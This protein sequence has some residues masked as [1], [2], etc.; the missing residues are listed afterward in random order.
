MDLGYSG[1]LQAVKQADLWILKTQWIVDLVWILSRIPYCA[2]LDVQILGS[3]QKLDHSFFF[4]FGRYVNLMSSS[5]LLLFFEWSSFKL[6]CETVSGIVL[7]YSHQ[8]CCLLYYLC[9]IN[10]SLPLDFIYPSVSGCGCGFGF[11]QKC[12]S[13]WWIWR[14][15]GT[16]LWI[17]IPLFTPSL[18]SL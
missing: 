5:K 9:K 6:R 11:E 4:S 1:F 13:I 10:T 2:C 16:D 7:C 17:C 8:A 15:K 14:K 12:R 3:K 18:N